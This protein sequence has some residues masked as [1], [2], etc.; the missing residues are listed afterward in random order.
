MA[1]M[2]PLIAR[3]GRTGSLVLLILAGSVPA[4]WYP[5]W[6]SRGVQP[7]ALRVRLISG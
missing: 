7:A 5:G 4:C 1:V 3:S 2:T 6:R